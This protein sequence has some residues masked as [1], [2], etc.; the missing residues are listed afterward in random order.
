MDDGVR[1]RGIS[2]TMARPLHVERKIN[3]TRHG[4][5]SFGSG[6]YY[7]DGE[8]WYWDPGYVTFRQHGF[9]G[10]MMIDLPEMTDALERWLAQPAD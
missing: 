7:L 3:S 5:V 8:Q 6:G 9:G 2:K 4:L 1:K 10:L